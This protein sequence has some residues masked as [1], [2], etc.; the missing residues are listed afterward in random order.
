MQ[1]VTLA[2]SIRFGWWGEQ[3]GELAAFV[4]REL[5]A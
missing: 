1:G 5:A 2:D 3:A 4:S